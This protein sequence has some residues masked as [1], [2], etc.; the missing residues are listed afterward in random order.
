MHRR[1]DG[2]L[3]LLRDAVERSPGRVHNDRAP[4]SQA[5][6]P[7][8]QQPRYQ[9]LNPVSMLFNVRLEGG[10]LAPDMSTTGRDIARH[11]NT[12]GRRY[13]ASGTSDPG[14]NT[15]SFKDERHYR[16]HIQPTPAVA[17]V[18]KSS[19][20]DTA[21][22]DGC[23]S[24]AGNPGRGHLGSVSGVQTTVE[25]QQF[26]LDEGRLYRFEPV[27]LSW[28]PDAD[29]RAYSRI[30]LTREGQLLKTPL[31]S[32]DSSAQGRTSVMLSHA[33]G[34]SVVEVKGVDAGRVRPVDETG[35]PVQLT[36]IGLVGNVLYGATADG[37]L[38]RADM[39]LARDG[40]LPMAAQPLESLELALKGAVC[41][42]G[43]FHDDTGQLNAL[44]RDARQQLHSA[45]LGNT[46]ALRPQ[47]NLSDVWVKG[48][49]KGIPLPSQHALATAVDL[50]PRG[51]VAFDAGKLLSWNAGAQRWD[52]C[53][54][55][56][57]SHLERG[58]DGRAYVL[59]EGQ[60][61]A[62]MIQ[63]VRDPVF[64]GASHELSA[65][66]APRPRLCVDE[67][68]AGSAQ[69]PITGFAVADGQHFVIAN[70][71]H[72][73]QVCLDG[74]IS[75][76][77]LT[78][79]F[80]IKTLALDHEA[81]LYAQ[82][83]EGEL[84]R[85]DRQAWQ[86]RG[87]AAQRWT[88][89][90]LPQRQPLE[91]L[92][93]GADK[94]L[95][96]GWN[97]QF[98]RLDNASPT[99][100][101]WGP[102][103]SAPH[104]PSLA[105]KLA[106]SQM[107]MP[108]SG[109]ALT[110]SSNVMGQTSEGV[111]TK[112]SF[113]QGL[114][115]HFHP[116]Q[117]LGEKGRSIQHYVNG[118]R[119]LE[120]V[121]ADDKRLHQEL[122][123]LSKSKQVA[124]DLSARLT[125][126]SK[127]GPRQALAEQISQ[128]LAQVK[129][130]SQS[131]ARLLGDIHGVAFN[132]QP[133]LSRTVASPESTLHQLY[134]AFKRVEPFSQKSTATLLGNFEG[135]G[136]RLPGW[137]PERKRDLSHP[138]A[139]IEG[140]LIQHAST[141]KQLAELVEE[142]SST[143]GHSPSALKRIEASVQAVMKRFEESPVHKLASQQIVSYDQAE[144]LYD[145]FKLLAKDLGTPGS[146]LHWHLS[147][148]LGLP[149]DASIKDAMT[150]QVQQMESGQTLSPSR[151]QGKSLGLIV[152]GIKPMAPLEFFL[153]ASKSHTHGVSISRTEQGARIEISS[154]A[155]RRLAGSV[156]SGVTLGQGNG[157]LS[158]G[159]RVAGEL[160]A[161]VAK[162]AGSS[163]GFDVKEADFAKMMSILMGQSG[164]FLDLL[165]LGEKHAAGE[166][167]KISAE[168]SLNA[169]AQLRL[170]Y[171]PQ[172]NIAEFDSV[173]RSGIGVMGGLSLAHADKSQSTTRS[174]TGTSHGEGGNAQWLKQ[175]GIGANFAPINALVLG[176]AEAG[177]PMAMAYALP[178]VSVMVKF[179]RGQSRAF[180]FSFKPPQSVTQSQIDDIHHSLS[181]YSPQFRRD[182]VAAKNLLDA[183]GSADEQ[184]ATL[185]RFLA[186][187]PPLSTKPDAY[188]AISQALDGLMTQQDLMN[189]GLRQLASVE[190]SVTR[191]GLRDDGRFGW[192]DDVAPGNKAAV[193]QWIKDDPQFAQVLDQ[194]Q[195]GGGTSVRLGMELKP[196]I[197]RAIERSLLAGE[198]AEA[199]IKRA[200]SDS[201]NLRVKSMS[202]SYTATQSH[203]MSVPAI[204]SLSFFSSAA[205][206]HTQQH[207]NVDFE[208]GVDA[209]KPLRIN[210]NDTLSRLPRPDLTID[211]ADQR[212]RTPN[213]MA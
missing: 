154:D 93:M 193:E 190:S 53:A 189:R 2:L 102:L 49:E 109:G 152:T 107:R 73:L 59:Q 13:A 210:L 146:A 132:S 80:A 32:L 160:M 153:E 96:G 208:Y 9:S 136:L 10:Q 25:G 147:Q 200:L 206:S 24:P 205:L 69:T 204:T 63:K 85:L 81:N 187:H 182:L 195:Q 110:V 3:H 201:S 134:E 196:E 120:G 164:G 57:V 108:V 51:K 194:L 124:A 137:K 184:L 166:S 138:S 55:P 168:V 163:I 101:E 54:Q 7:V 181:R 99:A 36:R 165:A 192:L 175:G 72:Q 28:L 92:R 19:L 148:L 172:E 83:Q 18:F 41:V 115:A 79:A 61:K 127:P 117:A 11:F 34:V 209:D 167:S 144:S 42:E 203:A 33:Q 119:G 113:F 35:A 98:H 67:V 74:V 30:G 139:I 90:E 47:W 114:K 58:L 213:V 185:Q 125:A 199:L 20:P 177:G 38:L 78:P 17:A 126:L 116:M 142:L 100:M 207:V 4:P 112:R 71:N 97:K 121:Y 43:F 178:E 26:R 157:A 150:R 8:M 176:S 66:P 156:G 105:D 68:L 87:G 180:S 75:R 174:A 169:L 31:G 170:M 27:T 122:K 212:I 5:T 94:H 62:V 198:S 23:V 22:G 161:A 45:P 40:M 111:S 6:V 159:L 14:S 82:S 15:L 133:T 149:A 1:L 48:I 129:E 162:N 183:Q 60:L 130:S 91:S 118:R 65:L 29:N 52:N 16:F 140:D 158:P 64:E 186:T 86:R 84:F 179:D 197:L 89:V 145:N 103:T 106:N 37:E 104:A 76:L 56:G 141:L 21:G 77:A 135:Q 123:A 173:I 211:L 95:I 131:S 143:P 128:A 155:M 151:T 188:H 50:G 39:R 191:V 44:V 70:K 171:N 202:M 88:K 12:P 46:G